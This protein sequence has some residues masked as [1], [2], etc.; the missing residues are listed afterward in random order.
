MVD[1]KSFEIKE[2]LLVGRRVWHLAF[3]RD[4]ELLLTS[5]GVSGDV[6]II[7]VNGLKVIKTLKVGRYPWGIA[8]RP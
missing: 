3:A 7:D 1:A 2:Y 6:S 4:Q 5:N 8:V